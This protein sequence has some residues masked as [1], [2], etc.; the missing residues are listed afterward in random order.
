VPPSHQ[1]SEQLVLVH[2]MS[3]LKA[4]PLRMEASRMST[5]MQPFFL[6]AEDPTEN[7]PSI[8]VLT[9]VPPR[10]RR[11]SGAMAARRRAHERHAVSERR[12]SDARVASESIGKTALVLPLL[13]HSGIT[14][15]RVFF[16]MMT[17]F[18][19][20][21]SLTLS[22][23]TGAHGSLLRS[24]AREPSERSALRLRHCLR[25]YRLRLRSIRFLR[26]RIRLRYR[27]RIPPRTPPST[28]T[29]TPPKPRFGDSRTFKNGL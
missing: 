26:H 24:P 17:S 29:P 23:T 15:S 5:W 27:I 28:T 20:R 19:S 12:E 4:S 2:F 13:T 6:A 21:R 7:A 3:P 10:R 22:V 18:W 11:H 9:P 1:R 25:R 16:S 8:V 14:G